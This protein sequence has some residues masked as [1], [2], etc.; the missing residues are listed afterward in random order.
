MSGS[1]QRLQRFVRKMA[2]K[3]N[4]R[5]TYERTWAVSV[6]NSKV[7][8]RY[9]PNTYYLGWTHTERG[10]NGIEA[11]AFV[12]FGPYSDTEVVDARSG[13]EKRRRD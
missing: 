12:F 7:K 13:F 4:T 1:Q 11:Q 5:L 6:G 8:A 3:T 10:A 9:Q 2:R